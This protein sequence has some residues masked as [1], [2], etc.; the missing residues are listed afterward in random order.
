MAIQKLS[1]TI[2]ANALRK[3]ASPVVNEGSSTNVT[4]S[5]LTNPDGDG[6]NYRLAT[7]ATSGSLVVTIPGYVQALIVDGGS[8]GT[9]TSN[10]SS[11][12]GPGGSVRYLPTLALASG[13]HT[14]TI[15]S[16]GTGTTG[17]P[18]AGGASSIGSVGT[19]G[20]S[21]ST[22]S[23][24]AAGPASSYILGGTGTY[25]GITGTMTAY[26]GGGGGGNAQGTTSNGGAGGGGRGEYSVNG[27]NQTAGTANTGGGGGGR[28]NNSSVAGA[29]GG[30]GFVAVRWEIA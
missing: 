23:G 15:G 29:N 4:F 11:P 1:D 22:N 21:A 7:W 14:V 16:G 19:S 2:T 20:G 24:G 30:S 27:A 13:T 9:G 10:N 28:W 17:A 8:S 18:V 12:G 26:G 3:P 25:C 6:K 5:T